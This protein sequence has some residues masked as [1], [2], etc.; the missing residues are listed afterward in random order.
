MGMDIRRQRDYTVTAEVEIPIYKLN[1]F[2]RIF[3]APTEIPDEKMAAILAENIIRR[4]LAASAWGEKDAEWLIEDMQEN[5]R[6][7]REECGRDV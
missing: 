5:P 3:N 4:Y 7:R 2:R 6:L 1:E